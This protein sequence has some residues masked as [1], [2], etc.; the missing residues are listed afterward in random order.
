MIELI[1]TFVGRSLSPETIAQIAHQCTFEEMKN[2]N[3]VNREMLPVPDLFDMSQSKFMR[4][5]IIGDW[6]THFSEEESTRFDQAYQRA[7]EDIGLPVAYDMDQALK[8]SDNEQGRI[9]HVVPSSHHQAEMIEA[10]I[11]QN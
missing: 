4:K 8:L 3:L 9:V 6:R 1:S 2:N 7:L 10:T 11:K 5:G